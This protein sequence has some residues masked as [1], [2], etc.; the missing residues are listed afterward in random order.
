MAGPI[1][2]RVLRKEDPRLLTGRGRYTDD[3]DRPGQL[4]AW[5]LRS[6]LAHARIAHIETS[7][8]KRAEGVVAVLTGADLAAD[9][10]GGLPCGWLIHSKDGSPMAEPPHPALVADRARHVG[11]PVA[12]VIAETRAQ[13][14]AASEWAASITAPTVMVE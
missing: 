13:A 7:E 12:V 8:A 2:E 11:D 5:I 1:G 14:K 4:H 3:I 9:G 6:P 10:V